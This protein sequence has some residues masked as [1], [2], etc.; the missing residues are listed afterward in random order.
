MI[1]SYFFYT[2]LFSIC[3][4]LSSKAQQD[5]AKV[6][7]K[8]HSPSRAA[9]YSAAL[10]GLGQIYNKKNAHWKVPLLCIGGATLGYFIHYNN[11]IHLKYRDSYYAK[12]Y[13]L[14]A[15]DPYP[16][17]SSDLVRRGMKE[18]Q[19]NRDLLIIITIGVYG[20]NVLDAFVEAHLKTFNVDD[21][22]TL[23]VSPYGESLAGQNF[24][25]L[26]LKLGF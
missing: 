21:K 4:S 19:H 8:V 17:A 13:N 24:S 15:Q 16:T 12:F 11:Q 18:F 7:G 3:L 20:L 1:K 10:P 2:L 23:R 25:G 26:S 5:T 9:L 22:L 6:V 14:P